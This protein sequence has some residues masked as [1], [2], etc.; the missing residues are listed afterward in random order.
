MD[1][2]YYF[3][4]ADGME[5]S[6]DNWEEIRRLAEYHE[7]DGTQIKTRIYFCDC[8]ARDGNN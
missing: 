8:A 1:A 3:L 7:V 6:P 5:I 4:T 2:E